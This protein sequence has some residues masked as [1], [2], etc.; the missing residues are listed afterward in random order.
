VADVEELR[1]H[2]ELKRMLL[3]GHSHGGVVAQA[4]AAGHPGR[5]RKLILASTLARFGAEQEAAMKA[6]MEKRSSQPWYADAMAALEAEQE[7][8]FENDAQM[9]ELVFRELRLYFARFG[10]AESG[11]LETLKADAPNADT[12]RV[13]NQEIFSTFDLRN[14]HARISAPTLVIT[15]GEDFICGPVCADE[16]AAGVRDAQEVILGDAG[17][18]IFVEQPQAFYSEVAGF[19]SRP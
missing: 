5:V 19:L 15:G 2:L 1:V 7:G 12:L 17:H 11:Y 8:R 10:P 18:F 13:F 14:Q 9:A 4:Y 16:I 6:G 3:L